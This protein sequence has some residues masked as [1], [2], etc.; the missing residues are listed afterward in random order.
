MQYYV[1]ISKEGNISRRLKLQYTYSKKKLNKKK[2]QLDS[3][4]G[5]NIKE[6]KVMV[7]TG[8]KGHTTKWY[9]T[10]YPVKLASVKYN[11]MRK[12]YRTI[13]GKYDIV[14]VNFQSKSPWAIIKRA[15]GKHSGANSVLIITIPKE[16]MKRDKSF[17][18]VNKKVSRISKEYGKE[19]TWIK[20]SLAVDCWRLAYSIKNKKTK[21]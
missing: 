16:S 17:P 21:K 18:Y 5:S 14:D 2:E 6:K 1:R 19:S 15:I 10:R 11:L 9:S 20:A 8:D 7:I 12:E 13:R 3:L 4:F